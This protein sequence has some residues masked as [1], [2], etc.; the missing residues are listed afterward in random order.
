MR[1]CK[2]PPLKSLCLIALLLLAEAGSG[3]PLFAAPVTVTSEGSR[4]EVRCGRSS[5]TLPTLP[6]D[7]Y[8]SLPDMP[9]SSGT[10]YS[11]ISLVTRP[12]DTMKTT[13][14]IEGCNIS[15]ST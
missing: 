5:F 13:S 14:R 15:S 7:D 12:V 6:V 9:G 3:T 2:R 10:G 1:T 4:V 8:P 11:I